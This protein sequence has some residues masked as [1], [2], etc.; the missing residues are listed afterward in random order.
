MKLF[1]VF[2]I[3]YFVDG[4]LSL[5]FN[6]DE[7]KIAIEQG[8]LIGRK[9]L[10][11]KGGVYYSFEGIP[12]AKPPVGGLRFK[13]PEPADPLIGV[14]NA[15]RSRAM[16]PQ[17]MHPEVE[18]SENCLFVN[19]YTKMAEKLKPVMVWIHGGVF[20]HGS[21]AD[22][23]KTGPQFLI[24]EDIV[25][26]QMQYRLNAFGFLSIDD[27]KYKI[28]GNAGFKDQ[29]L[30]LKWVQKYIKYFGGDPNQV[31]IFGES[32]GGVAVHMLYVSPAAKGLFH[33]AIATSGSAGNIW[34]TGPNKSPQLAK[35]LNCPLNDVDTIFECINSKST[36]E[37]VDS[38]TIL[39]QN[40]NYTVAEGPIMNV[41]TIEHPNTKNAFMTESVYE[42]VMKKKFNRLPFMTGFC[43][44]E[45]A[46]FHMIDEFPHFRP[47]F[48]DYKYLIPKDLSVKRGTDE[49]VAVA[50]QIKEFYWGES[51]PSSDLLDPYV[52]YLSDVQF[53]E[54]L[55]HYAKMQAK[56][57]PEVPL[58]FFKLNQYTSLNTLYPIPLYSGKNYTVHG[59][60]LHYL[61]STGEKLNLDPKSNE[62]IGINRMV[63]LWTT[64]AK[65]KN[66]YP[67]PDNDPLFKNVEWKP[68]EQQQFNYLHIQPGLVLEVNPNE[69]RFVFWE[70]LYRKYNQRA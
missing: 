33:R 24:A 23:E 59:D 7:I 69:E 9:S 30:A 64:F 63:K 21:I 54:K 58:Y 49:E 6:Q 53:I 20:Q 13:A 70:K 42:T 14:Y 48:T 19:V 2:V 34:I 8:T 22:I 31:T 27:P 66:A 26:V 28:P 65:S 50:Q 47:N 3:V 35:A 5:P 62:Y 25:L 44:D 67:I 12:Y 37:I 56:I 4:A 41:L 61:F 46:L 11:W 51:N 10:D 43:A 55:Y 57:A 32:A 40:P 39:R 38:F 29:I 68:V 16:C 60:D 45:S 15:T 17:Q 18:Q 36:K 52:K 1:F